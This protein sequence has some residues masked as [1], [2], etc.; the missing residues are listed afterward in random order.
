VPHGL[1][2]LSECPE[3]FGVSLDLSGFPC[4]QEKF[5][6]EHDGLMDAA[7]VFFGSGTQLIL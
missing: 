2:C 5:D 4:C 3:R 6:R 7:A 1:L